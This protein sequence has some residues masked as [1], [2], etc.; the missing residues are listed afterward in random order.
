MD[1]GS[2]ALPLPITRLSIRMVRQPLD[3]EVGDPGHR[4][5][6]NHEIVREIRTTSNSPSRVRT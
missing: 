4:C 5:G 6:R 3:G 2:N 1:R